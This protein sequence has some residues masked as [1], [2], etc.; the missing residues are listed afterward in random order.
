[1]L[2]VYRGWLPR[3]PALPLGLSPGSL[4]FALVAV[5]LTMATWFSLEGSLAFRSQGRLE[6]L[7]AVAL[8]LATLMSLW[9]FLFLIPRVGVVSDYDLTLLA[10]AALAAVPAL[11]Q[12]ALCRLFR[13][14]ESRLARWIYLSMAFLVAGIGFLALPWAQGRQVSYRFVLAF[15]L[16][17][18]GSLPWGKALPGGGWGRGAVLSLL[19]VELLW[20]ANAAHLP[21]ALERWGLAISFVLLWVLEAGGKP[22]TILG[23]LSDVPGGGAAGL[24]RK[25]AETRRI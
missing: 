5:M 12:L 7:S 21:P 15:S 9:P 4:V 8:P 2:V 3:S 13:S 20:G 6:K 11:P 22:G 1:M 16:L 24:R 10:I 23:S 25:A 19:Q 17:L 14:P 18:A